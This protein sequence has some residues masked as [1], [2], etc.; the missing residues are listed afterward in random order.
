MSKI[1][2]VD[3]DPI[4]VDS[5]KT[6]FEAKS[7]VLLTAYSRTEGFKK[8]RDENPNLI[9]LGTTMP[10]GSAFELHKEL[11]DDLQYRNI[12]MLVVDA[13]PENHA[14]KGWRRDEG[15]MLDAEDYISRPVE[16]DLLLQRVEELLR[17]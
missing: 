11:K 8:V 15:L 12:P 10:R 2:I 9:L 5:V 3:D 16:P 1:L 17:R 14:Q 13:S 7:Y 4:F 6:A